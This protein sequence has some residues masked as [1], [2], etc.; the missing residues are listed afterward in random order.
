MSKVIALVLFGV[1][2][3]GC[4]K[5]SAPLPN[6][7]QGLFCHFERPPFIARLNIK[8]SS[9][10]K[11]DEVS[12]LGLHAKPDNAFEE[13]QLLS[14]VY[15]S[16]RSQE[17]VILGD[18]NADCSYLSAAAENALRLK[19]L[20]WLVTRGSDTNTTSS[21]S[22]AYDR[23]ITDSPFSESAVGVDKSTAGISDHYLV[24]A[25]V[26]S[27]LRVA[28]FNMQRYGV[29]KAADSTISNV[30]KAIIS[31]YDVV[32]LQEIE[33]TTVNDLSPIL[34]SGFAY[35]LSPP[36]GTTSY[37]ERYA[38]VYRKSKVDIP[39]AFTQDASECVTSFVPA[40]SPSTSAPATPG[41]TPSYS[42]CGTNPHLTSGGYCYASVG[43]SS[44]RVPSFCCGR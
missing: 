17:N 40:P 21:S 24:Y 6:T 9:G 2:V 43:G 16:V 33:G 22:C 32:F 42:S 14:G 28:A 26:W 19:D 41:A 34:P 4:A 35:V 11:I 1:L 20:S 27:G 5:N 37:K 44:T 7:T 3:F 12:L 15:R 13:L 29:T 18:F 38:Y 39:K 31:N 23:I 30:L 25:T 10:A 8:D 36:Q